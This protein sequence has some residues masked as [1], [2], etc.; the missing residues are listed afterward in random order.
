M[1]SLISWWSCM[2]TF[3]P[4]DGGRRIQ[5]RRGEGKGEDLLNNTQAMQPNGDSTCLLRLQTKG[6]LRGCFSGL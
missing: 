6:S 5:R 3:S 1:V 2:H 4:C